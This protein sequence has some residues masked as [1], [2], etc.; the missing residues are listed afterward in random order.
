[1]ERLAAPRRPDD[2]RVHRP[3][4]RRAGDQPG[5][6]PAAGLL[7]ELRNASSRASARPP[8]SPGRRSWR[9]AAAVSIWTPSAP[10]PSRS[11][12][13]FSVAA[14]SLRSTGG[15]ERIMDFIFLGAGSA[16]GYD[17]LGHFLRTEGLGN[18]LPD[19]RA[20]LPPPACSAKLSTSS[21]LDRPRAPRRA[22][23]RIPA[24]TSLVMARTLAV[25]KGATPAQALAS[26]PGSA[27]ARER[28]RRARE[29]RAKRARGPARR[30]CERRHHLLHARGG[31]LER[32]R[33]APQLPPGELSDAR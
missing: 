4:H 12:G 2:A 15:L 1:M 5:L 19:L 16:N 13:N 14:H 9:S 7:E 11:A 23:S 30:R 33:D 6:H 3:R 32:R 31:R 29:R 18:D 22:R 21:G 25:L 8:N 10:P 17:A 27:P 20:R 28:A 24:R 26:Y